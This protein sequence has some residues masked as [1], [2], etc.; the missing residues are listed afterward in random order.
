MT[1]SKRKNEHVDYVTQELTK[2]VIVTDID[3]KE[4]SFNQDP[5]P[6]N[7]MRT[8]MERLKRLNAQWGQE[9]LNTGIINS[10]LEEK[11]PFD[12]LDQEIGSIIEDNKIEHELE[13]SLLEQAEE[14][15]TNLTNEIQQAKNL[16]RKETSDLSYLSE[17]LSN[18]QEQRHNWLKEIGELDDRQRAS[19]EKIA[20][21]QAEASQE[22]D[23]IMD[24]EEQRKQQVPRLKMTISLFASTTGI[25]WDFEDPDILSGQVAIPSRC[26]FKLFN[27]DPRDYSPVETA[28]ILWDMMDGKETQ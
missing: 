23:M 18:F 14:I 20:L 27:V 28:D 11:K 3:E 12:A 9:G 6:T 21:Y 5:P 8:P 26:S 13:H 15:Q 1:A 7:Q 10:Q 22:L 4:N 25:K 19:Q 16:Y 24:V 2:M 17:Q